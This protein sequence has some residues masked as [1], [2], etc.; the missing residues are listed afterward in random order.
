MKFLQAN[1]IA[2]DGTP[3]SAVSHLGLCCLPMSH[4]RDAR[5]KLVKVKSS[6]N[7]CIH[8]M[9]LKVASGRFFFH[10]R[11]VFEKCIDYIGKF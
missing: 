3:R 11:E 7:L 4:K 5:L 1:R 6:H 2:P 9:S 8:V 10:F